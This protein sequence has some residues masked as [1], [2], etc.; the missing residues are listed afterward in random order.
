MLVSMQSLKFDHSRVVDTALLYRASNG[1]TASLRELAV[2]LL[3]SEQESPHDSVSDARI[4][5]QCAEYA[6]VGGALEGKP[7]PTVDK[8]ISGKHGHG[9]RHNGKSRKERPS[10]AENAASTL[11]VHR[12]PPDCDAALVAELFE[13]ET[14][15]KPAKVSNPEYGGTGGA[16]GRCFATFT[17]PGHCDLAFQ[18]MPGRDEDDPTALPAKRVWLQK[19]STKPGSRRVHIKI[20][21]MKLS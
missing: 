19:Q 10:G 3:G 17:S 8:G 11:L 4:A 16:T 14:S 7:L 15:V 9:T 5:Y 12:L 21:K 1:S 13:A 18:S 6:V 20:R 2:G